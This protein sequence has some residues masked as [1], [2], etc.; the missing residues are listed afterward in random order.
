M[1]YLNYFSQCDKREQ[2]YKSAKAK[3][4]IL[5]FGALALLLIGTYFYFAIKGFVYNRQLVYLQKIKTNE[6]FNNQCLISSE[7]ASIVD[8]SNKDYNVILEHNY[9][10]PILNTADKELIDLIDSCMENDS[11]IEH[12]NISNKSISLDGVAED[13]SIISKIEKNLRDSD[14][15]ENVQIYIIENGISSDDSET[16]SNEHNFSCELLLKGAINK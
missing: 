11:H 2:S 14:A 1:N 7:V 8:E 4:V 9:A 13:I 5:I 12:L 10:S 15:F 6:N 3:N 16:E